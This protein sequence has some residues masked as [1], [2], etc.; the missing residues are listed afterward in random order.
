VAC[1]GVGAGSD[2][3]LVRSCDRELAHAAMR[4]DVAEIERLVAAGADP[5]ALVD[6]WTPLHRAAQRRGI[7]AVA[8]LL[9]AGARV[10]GANRNSHTPLMFA[11]VKDHTATVNA[12]LAAGADV[13]HA[14][15]DGFTSL[16]GA[17]IWGHADAA[18]ALLDAGARTDARRTDGKRPIDVVRVPD[19][20][21][22]SGAIASP[23]SGCA[24]V[25]SWVK[26]KSNAAVVHAL[27]AA[28]ETWARRRPVAVA[29]YGVGW[30]WEE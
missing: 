5:S 1:R 18:R 20:C 2:S 25:C 4:G 27:L 8:A 16:H 11:A 21:G 14:D 23:A 9:A 26:R 30:E 22:C 17:S 6:D 19:R 29:C 15:R 7:D 28:A 13:H 12:L 24:Q 3:A 10:D